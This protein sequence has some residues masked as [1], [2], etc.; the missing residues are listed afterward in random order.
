MQLRNSRLLALP[1]VKAGILASNSLGLAAARLANDW[2][3]RFKIGPLLRETFENG[4]R[5]GA[6]CYRA[7]ERRLGNFGATPFALKRARIGRSRRAWFL[8]FISKRAP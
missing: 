8:H 2:R 5:F 7:A 3:D 4:R 6:S 1:R